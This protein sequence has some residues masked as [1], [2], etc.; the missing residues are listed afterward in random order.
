VRGLLGEA[1]AR[2]KGEGTYAL[3]SG[4]SVLGEVE[5]VA[6]EE[7]EGTSNERGTCRRGRNGVSVRSR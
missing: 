6:R 3:C 4:R 1:G 2:T 5:G 7:R